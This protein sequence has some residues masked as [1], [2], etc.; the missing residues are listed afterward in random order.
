MIRNITQEFFNEP[1]AGHGEQPVHLGGSATHTR[2]VKGDRVRV[3]RYGWR[4][5][6][7]IYAGREPRSNRVFVK[8]EENGGATLRCYPSE[9]T[10]VGTEV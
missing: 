3:D 7:G 2:I 8:F 10:A 5:K 1:N 6:V 9:L 4:D